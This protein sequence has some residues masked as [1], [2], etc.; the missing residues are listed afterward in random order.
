ML[1]NKQPLLT[2]LQSVFIAIFTPYQSFS[3]FIFF[4]LIAQYLKISCI[5]LFFP[6]DHLL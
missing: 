1:I 2:Y 6:I 3:Y 4:R 5:H